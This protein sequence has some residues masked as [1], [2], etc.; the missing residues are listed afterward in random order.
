M[1]DENYVK[2]LNAIKYVLSVVDPKYPEEIQIEKLVKDRSLFES[3]S[4]IADRNGLYYRFN[5][6]LKELDIDLPFLDRNRWEEEKRRLLEFRETVRFLEGLSEES[7]IDYIL[8]KLFN[9]VPHIP[10]DVDIFVHRNDKKI[11]IELLKENGMKCLHS[12]PAETKFK[13]EYK[14]I[15]IYNNICYIGVDFVDDTYLQKSKIRNDFLG[16]NYPAL[17]NEADFLLLIPHYLFGHRRITLLDFLHMRHRIESINISTCKAYA[18]KKGWGNVF[19]LTLNYLNHLYKRTYKEKDFIQFPHLF[20]H[21]FI[22]KCISEI[23]ELDMSLSNKTFL[24]FS[25]VLD[26]VAHD[27]ETTPLYNRMKKIQTVRNLVNSSS[28][29]IKNIRGDRKSVD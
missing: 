5:S 17:N 1:K 11:F 23:D 28:A 4:L 27:L 12:S 26:R 8:I 9:T 3:A 2:R 18:T 20:R 29:F 7:S 13:G 24:Y 15:D 14:K 21:D 16:V 6:R 19:D 10:R 25:F 22:M